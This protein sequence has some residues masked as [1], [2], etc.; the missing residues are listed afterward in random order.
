MTIIDLLEQGDSATII[1][2]Y[3][4]H[5]AAFIAFLVKQGAEEDV[6]VDIYQD[7]I[8]ALVENARKGKLTNLKSSVSTYLFA[9]G[10]YMLYRKISHSKSVI[11]NVAML[12]EGFV[13]ENYD[14]TEY[15][16]KLSLLNRGFAL[17]GDQCKK[18]LRLFFYEEKKLDEITR[19]LQYENKDVTKSQKS[20]CL[21]KL[22][23][24][25]QNDNG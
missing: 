24:L 18:L 2:L 10:K 11:Q 15:E 9:I 7:S 21:K 1:K 19:L 20:R 22:K 23:T 14:E 12:P 25:I 4:E 8:I 17:L 5:K 6:C 16:G 13:W 3:D